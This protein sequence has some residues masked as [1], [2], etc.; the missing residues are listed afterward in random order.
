MKR[1]FTAP[2]LVLAY[3]L[4]HLPVVSAGEID[5]ST[6]RAAVTLE[7][8]RTHQIALQDIA[9]ANGGIRAENTPGYTASLDYV[10]GL[11]LGAGYDVSVEN[12][13]ATSNLIAEIPGRDDRLVIVGAHLDSIATGPGINDNGSGTAVILEIALQIAALGIVPDNRVR[14]AWWGADDSTGNGSSTH[15]LNMTVP[16]R[17]VALYLNFDMLGSPNFVRFVYD[18][19]SSDSSTVN[20][21]GSGKIE[22]VFLD[23]FAAQGLATKPSDFSEHPALPTFRTAKSPVGGICGGAFGIKSSEEAGI[24]G[25]TVGAQYD[26]CHHLACDTSDNVS[27]QVLD[28]HADAAAHAVMYFALTTVHEEAL[29]DLRS[30]VNSLS[31]MSKNGL[32]AKLD[33]ALDDIEAGDERAAARH[34]RAFINQVEAKRRTGA[35]TDAEADSLVAKAQAIIDSLS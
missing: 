11:L 8:V 13:D 10:R 12:F 5:S 31:L 33:G 3:S 17:D 2:W 25:G 34:L 4:S 1:V 18:G 26:P 6:L 19:D 23:Y 7:G 27:L 15:V 30:A 28:E 14:F 35:L 24:F 32:L 9:D 21:D 16:E 29:E 20:P 22:E